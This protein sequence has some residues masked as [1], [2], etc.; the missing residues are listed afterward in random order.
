[1]RRR[2]AFAC[3]VLAAAGL[4][5]ACSTNES[6]ASIG[7]VAPEGNST[8]LM[9]QMSVD[10]STTTTVAELPTRPGAVTLHFEA[11]PFE[12]QPG[13]NNINNLR[14]IPQPELSGW[15]VGFRP[16]LVYDDGTI[17]RVDIVHLHHGVWLNASNPDDRPTRAWRGRSRP[18]HARS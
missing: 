3:S 13:Q 6:A 7:T 2:F 14:N 11:G 17:P 15:I 4:A 18:R 5:A 8:T 16:N 1:M 12:I 9:P 10:V